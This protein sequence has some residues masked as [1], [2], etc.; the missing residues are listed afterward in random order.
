M[1]Y[2]DF[3]RKLSGFLSIH[4]KALIEAQAE[5]EERFTS[6]MIAVAI[7]N[8]MA[9][10]KPFEL[11]LTL[12]DDDLD[13]R[14]NPYADEAGKI[15]N[16]LKSKEGV[17]L[18]MLYFLRHDIGIPTKHELLQGVRVLLSEDMIETYIPVLRSHEGKNL[19][20][21]I[22]YYRVKETESKRQKKIREMREA[23]EYEKFQKLKKKFEG[24]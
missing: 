3:A 16:F 4:N 8:E 17:S 24:A 21:T 7:D 10:E 1:S 14:S 13:W 19:K 22:Y 23:R 20:K 9:K 6:M 5:R 18:D 15:F 12:P 11:D 2:Y